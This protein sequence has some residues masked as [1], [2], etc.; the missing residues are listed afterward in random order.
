MKITTKI[1][2]ER[3]YNREYVNHKI[4]NTTEETFNPEVL[5]GLAKIISLMIKE[6]EF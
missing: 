2:R 3:L 1:S 4:M 6:G 5:H